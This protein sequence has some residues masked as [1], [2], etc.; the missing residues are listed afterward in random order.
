M[1]RFLFACS[2]FMATS[3]ASNPQSVALRPGGTSDDYYRDRL[4]CLRETDYRP[5]TL[6]W[7]FRAMT[8]RSH[9]WQSCMAARGYP[10]DVRW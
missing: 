5:P 8:E 3:C 1:K 2:L 9:Y 4:E 7:G 6:T 10:P